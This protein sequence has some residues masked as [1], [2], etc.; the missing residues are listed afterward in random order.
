M[1]TGSLSGPAVAEEVPRRPSGAPFT[2]G[3]RSSDVALATVVF[4]LE[5]IGV[6]SRAVDESGEF[7]LSMVGE[8][9]VATYLLLLASSTALLWRRSRPLIVLA[10]TLMA[11]VV[12][13]VMGLA[14][15]PSL[16]ILVS[17]YGVGRYITDNRTS[18]LAV[19]ATVVAV[20]ADDLL[21]EREPVSVVGVSMGLV[22]A[23]W[24]VGRRVKGRGDYLA[25]VEERAEFLQRDRAAQARRAVD[26]E[27]ARIARELHDLV[28][29]R[30]SMM[31]VQAG[32]AQT[33]AARDPERAIRAMKAVEDEGRGALEEL[34]EILGV[35][36][37]DASQ[38]G[39]TPIH[40]LAE[41]PGLVA[42]M[43]E[44]GMDV[45]LSKDGVPDGLPTG[46]DLAV[47]RIVQEALTNVVKHAG[48]A[49]KAEVRLSSGQEI[50]AIEVTDRGAGV[51][52]LP[53]SGQGLVGMRERAALLGG[54]F[55]AGP[56]PGG[57]FR[58]M[59][60]IPSGPA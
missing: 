45:V 33:V 40:G 35:L 28:A 18:L 34:R 55:E 59:A 56:R 53:G 2:R 48:P 43:R 49:A 42:E 37:A 10:A 51:S 11:S 38:Q 25:L 60:R 1:V 41:I 19:S 46:V 54:T 50:L 16:A 20:V 4:I 9:P 47:Y 3:R 57:G 24:Y 32:A 12:W 22:L 31:T 30:V 58:V 29:H 13:D 17:L 52:T 21:V 8:A 6:L 44:A 15:G 39:L 23:A 7:S 36:R 27:R 14:D 5:V 26:E